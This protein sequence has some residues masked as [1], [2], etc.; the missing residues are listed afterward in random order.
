MKTQSLVVLPTMEILKKPLR[1]SGFLGNRN[2]TISDVFVKKESRGYCPVKAEQFDFPLIFEVAEMKIIDRQ[3]RSA[4]LPWLLERLSFLSL[5]ISENGRLRITGIDISNTRLSDGANI[6]SRIEKSSFADVIYALL[7]KDPLFDP[8][9]VT[10]LIEA[11]VPR[12]LT[13]LNVEYEA[14]LINENHDGEEEK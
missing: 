11:I 14:Y 13:K 6:R 3:V 9:S 12:L 2:Q 8:L 7:T 5:S 4:Y 10:L 1:F